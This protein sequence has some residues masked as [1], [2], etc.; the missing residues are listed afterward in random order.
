[1]RLGNGARGTLVLQSKDLGDSFGFRLDLALKA[2][3]ISRTE[4]AASVGVDKSLVSRWLSS[5]VT[6]TGHNL[7]RIGEVLARAK[8]GFNATQWERPLVEFQ[9][10]LG[11]PETP[12]A[13]LSPVAIAPSGGTIA[14]KSLELSA[15]EVATSAHVYTGLYVIFRQRLMNSGV[16][17]VELL[18]I[19]L[20][21]SELMWELGDGGNRTNGTAL[22]LRN[23]LHLIGEGDTGR[24]G[25]TLHILNGTGDRHAMVLDG[26]LCSVTGDR[27]FTP[28]VTKV[29][30]LR[31]AHPLP[32]MVE[33]HARFI[34]ALPR[35]APVNNQSR[36]YEIL[37]E[38]FRGALDNRAGFRGEKPDWVLRLPSEVSLARSDFEAANYDFP[39]AAVVELML[40]DPA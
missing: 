19:F 4:L 23:K 10:F 29:I 25:V 14:L 2:L 16:P 20:R 36:G 15:R 6:P 8:P 40:G 33:D 13:V 38:E 31:I 39:S 35:L 22:L 1:M 5:Q 3:N 28:A 26:L 18:R 32:D 11:V 30:L 24:D 17:N 21:D 9:A 37:P 34:Q 27:F 7:A 12:A